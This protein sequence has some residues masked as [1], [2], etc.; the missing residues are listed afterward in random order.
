[1]IKC[2]ACES[3]ET[4]T[5]FLIENYPI[6][7]FPHSDEEA[8][9]LPVDNILV[10]ECNDC[11]HNFLKNKSHLNYIYEKAY[12]NYPHQHNSETFSYREEFADFFVN[13]KQMEIEELL[14]IG[15]NNFNNLLEFAR[16]ARRV[17]GISLEAT[18]KQ[19]QNIEFIQGSFDSYNF[20]KKFTIILSKFVLEHIYDLKSHLNKVFEILN[21]PGY[22]I[23]QVPNPGKMLSNNVFNMLAHEHLHYFTECS[24][25]QLFA[26]NGFEVI[27][28]QNGNS[29]LVCAKK[30]EQV[31][32]SSI[33]KIKSTDM[34]SVLFNQDVFKN[35]GEYIQS[36]IYSNRKVIIYGAG[37]NLIGLFL[38][39]PALRV[40]PNVQIVD[41]N[42]LINGKFMPNSN[43]KI[44]RLDQTQIN[45]NSVIIILANSAYQDLIVSQIK[46]LGLH[47]KVINS[48]L[49][50]INVH[51]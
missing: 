5:E 3:I 14:E 6:S 8:M 30:S 4:K 46:K 40:S 17:T 19:S 48:K 1:M 32:D 10:Y 33:A 24:L 13:F 12:I 25:R 41:D 38:V 15:S 2:P 44:M 37:L 29:F 49:V 47:N 23:V 26:Q 42:Y 16:I 21:I 43:I 27:D 20:D 35:L 28:L 9:R 50:E 31:C 22:F 11:K 18:P 36:E 39:N 45:N 7:I 34:N 51:N